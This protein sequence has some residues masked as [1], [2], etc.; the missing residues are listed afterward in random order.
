MTSLA[1]PELNAE[2]AGP[3]T[4]HSP[5]GS[6][7]R[8]IAQRYGL[9]GVLVVLILLFSVLLPSSFAT[10][11]NF[12]TIVGSQTVMLALTLGLLL[13]LSAGEFDL[14][15]SSNLVFTAA[16]VTLAINDLHLTLVLAIVLALVLGGAIGLA[17]GLFVVRCGLNGF[18]TTLATMTALSAAA[19]GVTNQSSI[20]V[21]NATIGSLV[22]TQVLGL[23]V[24]VIYVWFIALVFWYLMERTP[25]GRHLRV[26]GSAREAGRLLG[27]PI[28]RFRIGAYVG[29]GVMVG[30]G[31]L[32]L[33]G[34]LG[35]I[36][37][38][39]SDQYLLE[40]YAAAFLGTVAINLGNF[41][42]LGSLIAIYIVIVGYTGLELAGLSSWVGSLFQ[43]VVLL[44]G[45]LLARFSSGR[46]QI[47]GQAA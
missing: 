16:I 22:T 40:P 2:G 39:S 34:N 1:E 9:V 38:T 11:S 25:F 47:A 14:S 8:H 7:A 12:R 13:P 32:L 43:G 46:A 36:D 17:N 37:P 15:I 20:L 23:P 42:V 30:F 10:G 33:L 27:L 35:S 6:A 24:D 28:K 31:A 3:S 45:L 41:N 21:N 4:D 5:R 44:A 19:L 26:T 29:A 18:I